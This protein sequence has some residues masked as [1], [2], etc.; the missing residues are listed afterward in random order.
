M[1]NAEQEERLV[2]EFVESRL[3]LDSIKIF[4]KEL[5]D[6]SLEDALFLAV[7]MKWVIADG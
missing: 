7:Y 4:H 6:G 2:E 5:F 1:T 3:S